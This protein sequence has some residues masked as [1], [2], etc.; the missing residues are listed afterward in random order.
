MPSKRALRRRSKKE[1]GKMDV[2]MTLAD[3]A[4]AP[5]AAAAFE[6]GA[7]PLALR[8]L[9]A[10]SSRER[11]P[12]RPLSSPL[13]SSASAMDAASGVATGDAG[14]EPFYVDQ[15][16]MLEGLES[17]ADLTGRATILS[18]DRKAER[19]AVCAEATGERIKVK[20]KCLKI[21]LAPVT[22]PL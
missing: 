10:T 5:A 1:K 3:P 22:T 21:I 12:R 19:V 4:P 20:K 11:S 17:R 18:F 13:A 6:L 2:P 9:A 15:V 16:V 14:L 7:G 8:R